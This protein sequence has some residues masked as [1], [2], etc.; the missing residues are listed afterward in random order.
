M[1]LNKR[2]QMTNEKTNQRAAMIFVC[3]SMGFFT[4]LDSIVKSVSLVTEPGSFLVIFGIVG[5][6]TT[7]LYCRL[8]SN[9]LELPRRKYLLLHVVRSGLL[10][11]STFL[12]YSSYT[13]YGLIDIVV[14][15]LCAPLFAVV[16]ARLWL[17]ERVLR[18]QWLA[19]ILGSAA[20][21]SI[22]VI[23]NKGLSHTTA[24]VVIG[25]TS[26]GVVLFLS[27]YLVTKEGVVRLLF[28]FYATLTIVFSYELQS[29]SQIA[30]SM[31]LIMISAAL[32]QS[33]AQ[34][35]LIEA[36]KRAQ[37]TVVAPFEYTSVLWAIPLGWY[38]F[39]ETPSV[40]TIAVAMIVV[41]ANYFAVSRSAM[42][43]HSNH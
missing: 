39:Q 23:Q 6:F 24:F 11:A 13:D 22:A 29:L 37:V 16:L 20:L 14:I 19:L 10:C 4:L 38:F 1:H 31:L 26:Y 12:L 43:E 7:G 27:R 5:I 42:T 32:L 21:V 30:T 2:S 17:S 34:L 3:I 18:L 9:K 35:L 41:V 33:F 25:A 15:W 40:I 28:S 8:T 36:Y